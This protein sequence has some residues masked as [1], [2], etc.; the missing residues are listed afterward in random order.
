MTS[1]R[2]TRWGLNTNQQSLGCFSEV[3][4]GIKIVKMLECNE[5]QE[6]CMVW[7]TFFVA[8]TQNATV[9][10]GTRQG[11][12]WGIKPSPV[13]RF[14]QTFPCIWPPIPYSWSILLREQCEH[15]V[16][17]FHVMAFYKYELF[18]IS[19]VYLD[20]CIAYMFFRSGSFCRVWQPRT[21]FGS[22]LAPQW[23]IRYNSTHDGS[24][25]LVYV[26]TF[27]IQINQM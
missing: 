11:I 12:T 23:Y 6:D 17:W 5:N 27:T 22:Q 14:S 13:L 15:L 21:E 8:G 18:L 20:S 10:G 26:P 24:M 16:S 3:K 2:A 25:G 7:I 1:K 4:A 9:M 19:T